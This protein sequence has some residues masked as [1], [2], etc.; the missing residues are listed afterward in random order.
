MMAQASMFR[1]D[2]VCHI[3]CDAR[4][5]AKFRTCSDH[6]PLEVVGRGEYYD[7]KGCFGCS[8]DKGF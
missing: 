3:E 5:G 8:V 6:V 4:F 1:C 7:Q 2:K